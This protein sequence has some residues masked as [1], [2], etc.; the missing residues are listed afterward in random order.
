MD[1]IGRYT[2]EMEI[3]G[4]AGLDHIGKSFLCICNRL[5]DA[6]GIVLSCEK[7]IINVWKPLDALGTYNSMDWMSNMLD[8]STPI[9]DHH[10][11]LE[12]KNDVCFDASWHIELNMET[13]YDLASH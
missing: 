12:N 6:Y 4:C 8:M 9:G 13:Q 11:F 10:L 2:T 1:W 5:I 3:K 7:K